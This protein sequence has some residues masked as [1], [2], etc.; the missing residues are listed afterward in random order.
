MARFD[1]EDNF[2]ILRIST[3]AK[4]KCLAKALGK[5]EVIFPPSP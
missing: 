2:R 4:M 3:N 1:L 5:E